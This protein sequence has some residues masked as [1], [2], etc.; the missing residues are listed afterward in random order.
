LKPRKE[1]YETRAEYRWARKV[2]N[3]SRGGSMF[4]SILIALFFGLASGSQ[5]LLF[6]LVA[7]AVLAHLG[8]RAR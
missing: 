7:F 1:D 3:E 5:W 2:H 6:G 4:P 8:A